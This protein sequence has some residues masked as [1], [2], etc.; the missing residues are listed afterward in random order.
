M[1]RSVYFLF[2]HVYTVVYFFKNIFLK[3]FFLTK[4][5]LC[6][7]AVLLGIVCA[8]GKKIVCLRSHG[9]KKIRV[10]RSG[11]LFLLWNVSLHSPFWFFFLKKRAISLPRTAELINSVSKGWL[12]NVVFQRLKKYVSGVKIRAGRVIGKREFCPKLRLC[13]VSLWEL[14]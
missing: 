13:Q 11:L 14:R 10:G 2:W 5:S 9:Q 4:H 3:L 6:I 12:K 8:L 1:I 7:C